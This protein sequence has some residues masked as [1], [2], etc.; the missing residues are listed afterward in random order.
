MRVLAASFISPSPET[1]NNSPADLILDDPNGGVGSLTDPQSLASAATSELGAKLWAWAQNQQSSSSSTDS[2]GLSQVSSLEVANMLS[3]AKMSIPILASLISL[4]IVGKTQLSGTTTTI[5]SSRRNFN[6]KSLLLRFT[7]F[8]SLLYLLLTYQVTQRALSQLVH[9]SLGGRQNSIKNR[10]DGKIVLITGGGSGIGQKLAIRL[11][12]MGR[13][14]DS[15][16]GSVKG[17]KKIILWDVNKQGMEETKR[18]ILEE[19]EKE[20]TRYSINNNE[21]MDQETISKN[22]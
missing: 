20:A 22:L 1:P 4:L 10:L 3:L 19:L 13:S 17:I 15:S 8:K 16:E 14:Y 5:G 21:K 2:Q 11:A 12:T 18:L 7:K 9:H 6:L